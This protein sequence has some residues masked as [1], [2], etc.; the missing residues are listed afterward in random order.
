MDPQ[1]EDQDREVVRRVLDGDVDAFGG[2]VRRWQGPL[3]NL[4]FRFCRNRALAEEMAQ[5][6]FLRAFRKL[7]LWQDNARFSTWLFS[8]ALNAYRSQMRRHRLPEVPLLEDDQPAT[9]ARADEEILRDQT[10]EVVRRM[11]ARLPAK[12]RDTLILVYFEE[13]GIAGAADALGIPEGTVKA[14]LHR[15]RELLK[16]KLGGAFGT[17]QSAEAT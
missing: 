2:I 4:A 3:V 5:E 1:A 6:A 8:L 12:Y 9:T 16:K 14:R 7:A 17:P 13:L 15:G 11:V 10:H